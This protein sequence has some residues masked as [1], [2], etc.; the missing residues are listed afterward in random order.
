MGRTALLVIVAALVLA[1]STPAPADPPPSS[2]EFSINDV[3]QNEG[4]S[5]TTSFV[6]TVSRSGVTSGTSTVG[7]STADDSASGGPS[8][9]APGDIDYIPTNGFLT[10]NA[11]D[12]SK[13]VTAMVCGDT[14]V[15]P[16]ETFFV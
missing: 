11:G 14:T 5:G 8:C 3:T 16:N 13:T 15:E 12:T 9:A 6:F 10:F 2:P 7:Y 1:G 4:N